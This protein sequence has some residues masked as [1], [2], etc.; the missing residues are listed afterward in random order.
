[1]GRKVN[2]IGFRLKINRTWDGRWYAEGADYVRQLHQDIVL[3]NL[4]R[5]ESPR[6]GVSRIEIERFP[7]KVKVMV[8]TAKPGVF[9][10][11]KGENVKK[12][13]HNL[14]GVT[15]KKIDLDIKEI[16]D[17]GKTILFIEHDM[18][19][20]MGISDKVIVINFGEVIAKGTPEEIQKNQNVIEAY[21]G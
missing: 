7:G 5:A 18:K 3:R 16:K 4:I 15:G 21:L 12:V 2:P 13:R 10:G 20:V 14:E 17:R 8:H 11:R 9:I 1:M 19:M 6:A